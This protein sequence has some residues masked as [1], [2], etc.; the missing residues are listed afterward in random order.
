MRGEAVSQR[1]TCFYLARSMRGTI[2]DTFTIT[3]AQ[4][5]GKP[6]LYLGGALGTKATIGD[7]LSV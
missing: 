4:P 2:G 7:A 1:H 5:K 6:R 3:K